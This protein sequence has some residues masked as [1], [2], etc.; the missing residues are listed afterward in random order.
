MFEVLLTKST[1]FSIVLSFVIVINLFGVTMDTETLEKLSDELS[2][3]AR[4][5]PGVVR[6]TLI[7]VVTKGGRRKAGNED[8]PREN[9]GLSIEILQTVDGIAMTTGRIKANGLLTPEDALRLGHS[10]LDKS[11]IGG[12]RTVA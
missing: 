8:K 4:S 10:R 12:M 7:K 2:A 3:T 9:R 1:E 11:L 6:T 5:F